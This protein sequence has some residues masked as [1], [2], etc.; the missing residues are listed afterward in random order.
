MALTRAQQRQKALAQQ[1]SA[2]AQHA[3]AVAGAR[4]GPH[5]G[6]A[7]GP[8]RVTPP[9]PP[10]ARPPVARPPVKPVGLAATP[11]AQ[12]MPP[13]ATFQADIGAAHQR[14][15]QTEAAVNQ[16]RQA[17]LIGAGFTETNID[18]KLGVGTLAFNPNDPFSKAALLKKNYDASR[19][20][21]A[22]QMGSGGG[23][24][25][26]AY[27]QAQDIGNRGQ[28]QAESA[29]HDSLF[30]FLSRNTG[31]FKQAGSDEELAGIRADS[32]RMGRID[33]NPLYEPSDAK[34]APAP[35]PKAPP[36]RPVAPKSAP[37]RPHPQTLLAA[38]HAPKV[39]R[40]VKNT[41]KG[42][43]VTHTRTV[44]RP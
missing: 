12:A 19:A 13:D 18:P 25:T 11:A 17:E 16:N 40:T 8:V 7:V 36:A 4:A 35:A 10:T 42:K 20:R 24:Y 39:K 34:P 33:T 38:P 3:R 41:R 5:I 29:L 44:N 14:R 23:L 6:T 2:A 9:P 26:G 28:V 37:V 22:Q 31:A 21:T 30:S 32:D 43:V 1:H 15:T 27:Q